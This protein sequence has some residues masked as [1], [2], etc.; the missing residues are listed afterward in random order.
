MWRFLRGAQTAWLQGCVG[1]GGFDAESGHR[2]ALRLGEPGS[3]LSIDHA[4]SAG[5]ITDTELRELVDLA[6]L[7]YTAREMPT[8]GELVEAFIGQHAAEDSTIASLGFR[9]R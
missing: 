9:L 1:C 5:Y 4:Y 2:R 8:L 3:A 6:A 7:V